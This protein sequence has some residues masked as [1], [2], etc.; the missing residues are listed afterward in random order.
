[1]KSY[2]KATNAVFIVFLSLGYLLADKNKPSSGNQQNQSFNKAKKKLKE[3]YSDHKI[4]F[5]CG[6]TYNDDKTINPDSCG[7]IPKKNSKRAKKIEWEHVV[8]AENFG[9]SFKEWREGDP[10]CVDRRGKSFKGR[11]CA[12][13]VNL[14]FRYMEADMYNLYPAIGELNMRR[15]NY[16]YSMIGGEKREFGRCD[17]EVED[18][19][20]E[21]RNEIFGDIART[22]FYMNS[23]YPGH[24]I[25]SGKN[26]KLFEAWDKMDP[27]DKWE[28]ERARRIK[29]IQGNTNHIVEE[30]CKKAGL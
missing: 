6:C 2:T 22:Y 4:T 17:F 24:G 18:R 14:K 16:S 23:S 11:N 5:Y 25:I 30:A 15:S 26:Q 19:K 8:P 27:V 13:K 28:C 10:E 21:P 7:Y 29:S 3:L 12:R 9:R 20:V 1:M